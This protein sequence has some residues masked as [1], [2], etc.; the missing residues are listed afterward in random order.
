MDG[1]VLKAFRDKKSGEIYEIGDDY[2]AES[3]RINELVKKGFVEKS[4][5]V[6]E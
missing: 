3:R 2:S 4:S 1:K 5:S 6:K